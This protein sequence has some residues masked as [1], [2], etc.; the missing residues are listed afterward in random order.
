MLPKGLLFVGL[1]W[2]ACSVLAQDKR[3]DSTLLANDPL[4]AEFDSLLSNAE[5]STSLFKMLDQ[6]LNGSTERRTSQML[7]RLGYN[8]NVNSTNRV[9]GLNQFG[10][11]PGISYYHRSGF[12][13]DASGY[14]SDEYDPNYYLT[15]LTAGFLHLPTK[16]WSFSTEYNR[17][18]YSQSSADIYT[19][20]TNNVAFSNFFDVKKI[21]FRLDYQFFF[22]DKSA[23][24]ISPGVMF[25]LEKRN[26]GV[27]DR[28]A[29]VPNFSV[30]FGSEQIVNEYYQPYTTRPLE[31][32]F[33]IR[34]NLPLYYLVT[35]KNTE[36]GVLN[37]ALATPFV[38]STQNWTFQISYTYNFPK[39]LS[40]EI[41]QITDGGFVS[42]GITRKLTFR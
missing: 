21:T 27:I 17:F 23:H 19:P 8:S 41:I 31:V 36:F 10:L 3:A 5:D 32:L 9:A 39:A 29:F 1:L 6:L 37:Y 33:R 42:M 15:V 26:L 2:S 25:N 4:I 35:E 22:G 11:S 13:L 40:G 16:W 28:L 18:I 24:R 12:Y 20:Y 14:W 34:N 38:L 30:L 7:F